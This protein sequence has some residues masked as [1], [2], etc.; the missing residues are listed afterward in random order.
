[1]TGMKMESEVFLL[2]IYLYKLQDNYQ[3][4]KL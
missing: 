1:M 3:L 2:F 4:C